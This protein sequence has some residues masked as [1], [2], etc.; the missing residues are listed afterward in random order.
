MK[1]ILSFLLVAILT[2]GLSACTQGEKPEKIVNDYF[3]AAKSFD[4][5]ALDKLVAG[6]F[7]DK[8]NELS[9]E[10]KELMKKIFEHIS[11]D[12]VGD[13]KI[14]GKTAKVNTKITAPDM[15]KVFETVMEELIPKV[16]KD[17]SEGKELSG[18]DIDKLVKEYVFKQLNSKDLTM[19]TS[20]VEVNLIRKDKSW[21]IIQEEALGD[22]IIGGFTKG[23]NRSEN[24]S[25]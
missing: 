10:D 6:E 17:A 19:V 12:I 1:K 25:K 5:E 8:D 11:V 9:E 20:E 18:E 14:E 16:R 23:M 7:A 13:A 24:K 3:S 4:N 15:K 21:E 2:L 22:A